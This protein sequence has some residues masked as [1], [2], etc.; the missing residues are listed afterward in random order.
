M[1]IIFRMRNAKWKESGKLKRNKIFRF[2]RAPYTLVEMLVVMA[3][4]ATILGIGL[5]A[6]EKMVKGQGLDAAI[7]QVGGKLGVARAYAIS[8]NRYVAVFFPQTD[9]GFPSGFPYFQ[10]RIGYV[11]KAVAGTY[12]FS[13]WAEGEDWQQLP[14]GVAI[15]SVTNPISVSSVK[16]DDIASGTATVANSLIFSPYGSLQNTTVPVLSF[17]EAKIDGTTV[18]QMNTSN[19]AS[20]TMNLFTGRPAYSYEQN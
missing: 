5:P 6:F 4:V 17:Q 13:S 18:T 2:L 1:E 10:Y 3:I 11:T 19:I 15:N 9:A 20:I 7:R 16:I 12:S 14:T 8:S